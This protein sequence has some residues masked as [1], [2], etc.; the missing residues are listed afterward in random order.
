MG[1]ER[2]SGTIRAC[3]AEGVEKAAAE[4]HRKYAVTA[5]A[6]G[7][8]VLT[9]FAVGEAGCV[10]TGA[11]RI[12]QSWANALTAHRQRMGQEDGDA[13]AEVRE[14]V[15]RGYATVWMAQVARWYQVRGRDGERQAGM[16]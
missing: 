4:K 2:W 12:V 7:D 5:L 6:R 11:A 14:A 10:G 15:G 8:M 13:F 9:V 1:R 16:R 3:D